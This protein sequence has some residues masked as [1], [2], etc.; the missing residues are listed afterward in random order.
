MRGK[1]TGARNGFSIDMRRKPVIA[2]VYPTMV[3]VAMSLFAIVLLGV[4][5]SD[6]LSKR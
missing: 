2:E 3:I 6:Q 1:A 4:S 5:V